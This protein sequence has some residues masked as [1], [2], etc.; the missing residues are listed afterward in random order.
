M[1]QYFQYYIA[2]TKGYSDNTVIAYGKDLHAFAAWAKSMNPSATWSTVTQTMIQDYVMFLHGEGKEN[3]TICRKVSA[4]RSLYNYFRVLG[5][6]KSNPAQFV[7]SPKKAKLVPH[8]VEVEAIKKAIG[9]THVSLKTKTMLALMMET[10]IRLQEMLDLQTSDFIKKD[11]EI[12]IRGKGAKERKVY[13]GEVSARLLN[14]YQ[15]TKQGRL[16]NDEQREVRHA[17]YEALRPYSQAKQV[18]PHAIRHTFATTMLNNGAQLTTLQAILGHESVKT[19][20]N[21]AKVANR[22]VKSEYNI[23]KPKF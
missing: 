1:I 6:V 4:I 12:I 10:G 14:A 13:Y 22:T 17:I 20:E 23:Y 16:F 19:T 11:R 8:T 7:S 3:S 9:S 15:G 18:S 5:L 2:H 21:Y